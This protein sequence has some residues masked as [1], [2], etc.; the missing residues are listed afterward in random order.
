MARVKDFWIYQQRRKSVPWAVHIF[1]TKEGRTITCDFD[2]FAEW[3]PCDS[4]RMTVE[5]VSIHRVGD[6]IRDIC[7]KY[8]QDYTVQDAS[9]VEYELKILKN[10]LKG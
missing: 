10:D 1:A 9:Q 7:E 3:I 2:I 8:D 5:S 6:Y 4:K